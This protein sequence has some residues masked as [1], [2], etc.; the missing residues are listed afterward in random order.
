MRALCALWAHIVEVHAAKPKDPRLRFL[1]PLTSRRVVGN[2]TEAQLTVKSVGRNGVKRAID[3]LLR[4]TTTDRGR[5]THPHGSHK[6]FR[7][8]PRPDAGV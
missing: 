4:L 7:S 6:A 8:V 1:Y 2:T 5:G 3:A